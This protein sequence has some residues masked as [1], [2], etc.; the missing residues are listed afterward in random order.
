M[1][2]V[3]IVPPPEDSPDA[4]VGVLTGS[5]DGF[6]LRAA[7]RGAGALAAFSDPAE[8]GAHVG[9][10]AVRAIALVPD[11]PGGG[12]TLPPGPR[13]RTRDLSPAAVVHPAHGGRQGGA[14]GVAGLVGARGL[15]AR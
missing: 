2:T 8:V 3:A 7:V 1:H 13:N 4:P 6:V 9:G 5:E 12:L 10:A 15:S 14:P 11:V